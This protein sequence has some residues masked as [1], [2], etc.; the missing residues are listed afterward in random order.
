[1]EQISLRQLIEFIDCVASKD[2]AFDGYI[3]QVTLDSRKVSNHTLFIAVK[4]DNHDGHDYVKNVVTN[5]TS[6]ALV[7]ENYP[8][9]LP[10]LIRVKDTTL[11]LGEIS[12]NYRQM[13]QIPVVAI[14]GSNGKTTVK[15]MLRSVCNK[16]FGV[17]HVL[18]T[19]G[20]LNNHWGMPQTL[21][22]LNKNHQVAIIEMGMNHTG[23]IDYLTNLAKPTIAVI[24]NV[25]FA[26]AGFFRDVA[27]IAKAKGEIYHGLTDDGIAC[28]DI[29]NKFAESWLENDIKT[30]RIFQ[31]GN[32]ATECYIDKLDDD[33]ATYV[34]PLGILDIKLQILGKHNYINALTVIALA[35]NIGCSL[36]SIKSGLENYTGFKGRLEQKKSYNGALIIDDTYNANPDS[37]RAALD[38]IKNLPKPHWFILGDLK[39]L[40]ER[41]IQFHHEIGEYINSVT[42]D[43]LITVGN[44]AQYAAEKY[45]RTKIHFDKNDDVVQYCID[46]LPSNATL[47]VKGSN[48]T[49]LYD[50]VEKLTSHSEV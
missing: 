43:Q 26:H 5:S 19:S 21:L 48:S 32:R 41:E 25:L 29:S 23:E 7:N 1:M 20:N 3:T 12:A 17:E 44:L 11:A 4:G 35:I 47:L 13:F 38:A 8:D 2:F 18:A 42:I 9:E 14:T 40:G 16:Q 24:N 10:N 49:K 50:V 22:Q 36:A 37:V 46:N 6:Y 45:S 31:Y 27:S 28:I 33:K 15:E 34:T 30:Q 39:E